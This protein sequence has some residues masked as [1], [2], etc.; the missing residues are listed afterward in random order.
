MILCS[1]IK[2]LYKIF[3][4]ALLGSIQL[5]VNTIQTRNNATFSLKNNSAEYFSIIRCQKLWNL[6]GD[7][8]VD[9]FFDNINKIFDLVSLD[10]IPFEI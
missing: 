10:K 7:E 9:V 6:A 1:Y 5:K 2:F 4:P 3:E 8:G